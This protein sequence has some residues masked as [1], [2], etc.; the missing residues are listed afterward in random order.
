M[1]KVADYEV[2]RR[3]VL[4][5]GWSRRRAARE[6]RHSRDTVK[7]ALE[8]SSPPGYVRKGECSRP[9]VGPYEATIEAWVKGDRSVRRK[10]R[11]TAQRI[12]ER[13]VEEHGYQGSASAVRRFVAALAP[14]AEVFFPLAF[15][16]G[17]EA[18]VDWGEAWAEINGVCRPAWLFCMR[19]CYSSAQFVCAFERESMEA[20]LEGH[21]RAFE[22]FGGVPKRLAYDNLK[23]AVIRVGRGRERKLNGDFLKL[24]SHYLFESRFCNVGKGNEKGHVENLVKR[25]QRTF[26]TPVPSVLSMEDLSGRLRASC[27]RDL[28][29]KVRRKQAPQRDLLEEERREM[30]PLPPAPFPACKTASTIVDKHSLVRVDNNDYS[31]HVKSAY[32][33]CLVRVYV[34]RVKVFAKGEL[35]ANHARSYGRGECIADP[36]HYLP[37]LERKRGALDDAVPF[38]GSPFGEA[39]ERFR[40]ELELRYEGEGTRQYVRV[41]MLFTKHPREAVE[42]AVEACL[43]RRTFSADAVEIALREETPPPIATLRLGGRPDLANVGSGQR[44][45][46]VYDAL[47]GQGVSP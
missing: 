38:K 16:P 24:R 19:L 35:V 15:D 30:L 27:E 25:A 4:L 36:F 5:E 11:H 47:I 42:A 1:L 12:Y 10:Q 31:V 43:G 44:P 22:F 2:I 17:Q 37:L 32:S 33:P 28:G 39:F 29:R 20:F 23:C 8:H 46:R 34:D 26:M 21:V 18:Q 3:K 6:L 40:K 13:L 9:V 14:S 7:K 45:A 41:L